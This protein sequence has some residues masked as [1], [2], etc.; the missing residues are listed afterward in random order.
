MHGKHGGDEPGARHR[1]AQH[2]PPHQQGVDQLQQEVDRVVARRREPPQLVLQ[3]EA[4]VHHRPV[5]PLFRQGGRREPDLPDAG[6]FLHRLRGREDDVVP[7]ESGRERR[8]VAGDHQQA[9]QQD[10]EAGM[11]REIAGRPGRREK[12]GQPSRRAAARCG[13]FPRGGLRLGL[14]QAPTLRLPP[15]CLAHG[16][17]CSLRGDPGSGRAEESRPES[18]FEAECHR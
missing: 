4:G 9:E 6:P 7:N 13:G 17:Q 2:H 14:P 3:P 11:D 10:A 16:P 8:V 1:E 12:R 15:A 18:P 5:V